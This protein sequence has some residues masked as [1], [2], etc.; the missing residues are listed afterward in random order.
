M[1]EN[2]SCFAITSGS[3]R[4]FT[5]SGRRNIDAVSTAASGEMT[6]KNNF[7]MTNAYQ[8]ETVNFASR[9]ES[10]GISDRIQVSQSV[11]EK[12]SFLPTH[13]FEKREISIKGIGMSTAYIVLPNL[14]I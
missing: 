6:A 2:S 11:Y 8:P 12:I 5:A 7:W 10:N 1:E 13:N 3:L 9:M 14:E 4:T